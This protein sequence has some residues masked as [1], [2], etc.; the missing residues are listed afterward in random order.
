[1]TT[2]SQHHEIDHKSAGQC[3]CY[4]S[5]DMQQ[6]VFELEGSIKYQTT[7]GLASIEA[8]AAI[9]QGEEKTILF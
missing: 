5:D 9:L 4:S 7:L 6:V 2:G 1:M 3:R 8:L